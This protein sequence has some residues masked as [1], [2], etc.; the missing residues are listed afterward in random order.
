MPV[1]KVAPADQVTDGSVSTQVAGQESS[2]AV[3]AVPSP[4]LRKLK[5]TVKIPTSLK[6]ARE[7]AASQPVETGEVKQEAIEEVS[8][9]RNLPDRDYTTEE[10]L[11]AWQQYAEKVKAA[12]R[13]GEYIVLKESPNLP[14]NHLIQV[15]ISNSVQQDFFEKAK[16]AAQAWLRQTLQNSQI[17]LEY[18]MVK[19][20]EG[21][22]LYTAQ[23]KFGYLLKKY[24][25]LQLLKEKLG[26]EADF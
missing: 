16:P 9:A 1:K 22:R 4:A 21:K 17:S 12:G 19:E 10:L 24:P 23:E 13:Q 18:I 15:K 14:G 26:L 7:L 2:P 5:S 20:E 8:P 6:S 25:D 11:S 3:K